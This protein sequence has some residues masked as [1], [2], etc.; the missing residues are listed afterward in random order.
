MGGV[1]EWPAKRWGW[2]TIA[3]AVLV[4]L[5]LAFQFVWQWH[6]EWLPFQTGYAL[7]SLAIPFAIRTLHHACRND[8][9]APLARIA[10]FSEEEAD[11]WIA[12]Q[13]DFLYQKLRPPL[14]ALAMMVAGMA[15]ADI[16]GLPYHGSTRLLFYLW[17]G[18]FFFGYGLVALLYLGWMVLVFFMSRLDVKRSVFLWPRFEIES[19]YRTS[20]R[21]LVLGTALY[22]TVVVSVWFSPG[23]EAII[24]E[25]LLGALWVFPPGAMVAL[26]FLHF[27]YRTHLLLRQCR[28]RSERELLELMSEQF[29]DWKGNPDGKHGE[30][31]TQLEGWLDRLRNEKLWLLDLK[32]T[33]TTITTIFLPSIHAL[34]E[35]LL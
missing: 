30:S 22:V 21:L 24:R 12:S 14:V 16:F 13:M 28:E 9:T 15:S 34:A 33:I 19:V 23:G 20:F 32:A 6:Q 35:Y 17:S 25:T 5:N 8:L 4:A 29:T 11:A 7:L 31:I 18:V 1:F 26:F 3:I 27:H 2:C 10:G